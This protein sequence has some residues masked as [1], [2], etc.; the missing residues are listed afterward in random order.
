MLFLLGIEDAA[1]ATFDLHVA[2][3]GE[4][5]SGFDPDEDI[6]QDPCYRTFEAT[7]VDFE[8]APYFEYGPLDTGFTTEHDSI[9]LHGLAFSGTFS[10]DGS[11]IGGLMA[12]VELD[13]REQMACAG[14]EVD[15][16]DL[17]DVVSQ[18]E[19]EFLDCESDGEPFCYAITIGDGRAYRLEGVEIEP[20]DEVDSDSGC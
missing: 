9:T 15:E 6:A 10:S 5:P 17:K 4:V 14:F 16:A 3:T 7:G 8:E 20:V 12:Q 19:L 1:D 2:R 11:W 18:Y 13:L